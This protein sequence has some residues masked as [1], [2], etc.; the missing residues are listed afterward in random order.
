[1]GRLCD[2]CACVLGEQVPFSHWSDVE[3][4]GEPAKTG[5]N[6]AV[7]RWVA[8]RWPQ[9]HVDDCVAYGRLASGAIYD[10]QQSRRRSWSR[11]VIGECP[12]MSS[13]VYY[14]YIPKEGC[15]QG[16][17]KSE[18]NGQ[19]CSS[20]DPRVPRARDLQQV[21]EITEE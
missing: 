17:A 12:R 1:M 7:K 6:E 13:G 2:Y 4:T 20:T 3:H 21:R 16:G 15:G 19:V 11:S 9:V 8:P 14:V 18:C 10:L 5:F